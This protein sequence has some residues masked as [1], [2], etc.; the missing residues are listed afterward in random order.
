MSSRLKPILVVAIV[1]IVTSTFSPVLAKEL[2]NME[3]KHAPLVD[4][5]QILGQLG[6]YNILVDP[7][8]SGEVSFVLKNLPVE[9]A[10]DLVARTTGYRYKLMGNTLIIASEQR[11]KS[12]FG[13]EDFSF[14]SIEHVNVVAAQRLVSLVVPGVRSYVDEEL[15]LVVLFGLSSDLALA[16]QVLMQYDRQATLGGSGIAEAMA[17]AKST[18][19]QD[20]LENHSVAVLYA[21]GI[22]LLGIVRRQFPHREFG[23]EGN[24]RQLSGW[25]TVEEWEQVRVL[26]R[27]NDLPNF[28]VK[29]ILSNHDQIVVL[30]EH[31]ETTTL[32]RIGDT[33]QDWKVTAIAEGVVEFSKGEH[34]FTVRIGR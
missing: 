32:L 20:G 10:L 7:S 29:G 17:R 27:E 34:N 8:V 28:V 9:E 30:V 23:W 1:L 16:E 6:G 13:T 14:V 4:V 19:Q 26:V 2:V 25:T 12:E 11:L 3:F 21:E 33:L 22:D 18:P 24:I 31:R 15:N 5:F